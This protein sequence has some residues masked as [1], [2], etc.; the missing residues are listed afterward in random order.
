MGENTISSLTFYLG[1]NTQTIS[2][3]EEGPNTI[4]YMQG[5]F[6]SVNYEACEFGLIKVKEQL[7]LWGTSASILLASSD[8]YTCGQS[9][10]I[11]KIMRNEK[12]ALA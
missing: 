10:W 3:V 12:Y 2:T 1:P 4:F 11:Q 7:C 6:K 5:G 8:Q 9:M